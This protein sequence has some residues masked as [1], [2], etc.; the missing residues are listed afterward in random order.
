M[1]NHLVH[2]PQSHPTIEF[3][4]FVDQLFTSLLNDVFQRF[5]AFSDVFIVRV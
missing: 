5:E 3:T 2:N 4:L 1:I